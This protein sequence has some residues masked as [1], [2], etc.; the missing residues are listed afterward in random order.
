MEELLTTLR[1][2]GVY[3]PENLDA[4]GLLRHARKLNPWTVSIIH[5]DKGFIATTRNARF[6]AKDSGEELL[7][8]VAYR[9]TTPEGAALNLILEQLEAKR[10]TVYDTTYKLSAQ[11]R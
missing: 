6:T 7:E 11:Q 9:D 1:D 5:V 4:A 3:V 8:A 2:L 10:Y